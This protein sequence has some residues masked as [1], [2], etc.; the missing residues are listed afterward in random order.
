MKKVEA[1]LTPYRL[2]AV[3]EMLMQHGCQQIVVSEVNG[4]H[5]PNGHLLNYQDTAYVRDLPRVRL[6]AVVR[7]TEA[8]S[9]V[10][11]ILRV[12]SNSSDTDEKVSVSLLE[13]VVFIGISKLDSSPPGALEI[14]HE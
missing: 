5:S 7:D 2:D 13:Q 8:M 4:S 1:I 14:E 10:H 11:E 6:E 9:T 12:S 3:K